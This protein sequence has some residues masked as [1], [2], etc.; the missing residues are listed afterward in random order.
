MPKINLEED[1]TKKLFD[2]VTDGYEPPA[3]LVGKLFPSLLEKLKQDGKFDVSTLQRFKIPT[4]EYAGKRP[5][6]VI[7]ASAAILGQ[8]APLQVIRTFGDNGDDGWRNMIVQGDNLQFLKTVF[9]NQDPLIKDKVKGKVKLIYIDPPFATKADFQGGEGEKSYSDKIDTAEF[10]ENLRER[11]FFLREVLASNGSIYLHLDQ[12]MVHYVKVVMDELFD[13]DFFRNEIVWRRGPQKSHGLGYGRNA[14]KILFYTKGNDYCWN[15]QVGELS[16]EYLKSF[17]EDEKGKYVTTPLHSGKPAKNVPSWRGVIPPS[18]RGWAYKIEML[19]EFDRNGIVEWSKSGIPRL[20]RYLDDIEGA[21]IQELWTD[22]KPLLIKTSEHTSYPTQ[23]PEALL[24]RII[25]AS[26]NRGDLVMDVFAGSG[27]TAAVAEKL[28][29][30]W[31]MCDFGKHAIYTMQKRI[32]SIADSK[33]MNGEK[34]NQKYGCPPKPFSVVSVGAYDFTRVMNLRE[35]KDAYISFV[36]A[37]FGIPKEEKDFVSKYKLDSIHA[38]KD[39]DPVEIFPVWDD[40]YLY[41]VKVDADYLKEIIT[42]SR[43][44]IKGDFYI[45]VPETCTVISDM[46]LPSGFGDTVHFKLLKFP[47]K[48]L[49]EVSRNFDLEEQPDSPSN[50]NNLISSVGF[51]FHDEVHVKAIKT[52][53]GFKITSFKTMIMNRDGRMY[54][55]LEGLSLILIDLNYDGTVF[56]LDKAFYAKEIKED[57]IIAPDGVSDK[58]AIIVIDK[59]GNESKPIYIAE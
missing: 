1:D 19:E 11:L 36:L 25:K 47:Y 48:I 14:D 6:G 21:A 56:K 2:A 26:S 4:L 32:W 50:I 5:E 35:N 31:I 42:Q 16:D 44:R 23:K 39:G 59:H 20:K 51:Y 13:K 52:N 30:R 8:S 34:K 7:L 53:G 24:E 12:K 28:G 37:L 43:G 9:L 15:K 33:A 45:I 57:G 38:E 18:G 22:I 27:T 40:D 17:K 10:L 46:T 41:N 49:E 54:E 55:G 3:E 29:R 58:T